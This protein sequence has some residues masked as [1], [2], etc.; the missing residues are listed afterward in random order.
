MNQNRQTAVENDGSYVVKKNK[1]LN[2]LAFI[3]C[4]ILAFVIWIYVMNVKMSDNIKTFSKELY[5]NNQTDYS[6]FGTVDPIKVTI[7]GTKADLQKY[8]EGD[9]KVYVNISSVDEVGMTPLNVIV[10]TPSASVNVV[11][12]DPI[13][14][15]L[16]IDEKEQKDVPLTAVLNNENVDVDLELNVDTISV[17]GPKMH[18]DRIAAARMVM[19]VSTS[20]IGKEIKPSTEILFVDEHDATVA[21]SYL[22]YD[23]SDI[24]VKVSE[25]IATE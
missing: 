16:M 13:V 2:I 25:K 20:D 17:V 21:S 3:G 1:R 4:V 8:T 15:T 12:V 5:I 11:S 6:V 19:R 10:E 9:F 18:V 23:A 7:Q 22:V 24:S 14:T